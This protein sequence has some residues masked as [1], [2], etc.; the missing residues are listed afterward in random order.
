MALTSLEG[1]S[2]NQPDVQDMKAMFERIWAV[3]ELLA[4]VDHQQPAIE[5]SRQMLQK[6]QG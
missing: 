5:Q 4:E 6:T 1:Q 2:D 3:A